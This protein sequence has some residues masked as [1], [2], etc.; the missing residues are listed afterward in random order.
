[1]K[2]PYKRELQKSHL[3]IHS[4]ITLKTSLIFTKTVL[5]NNTFLVDHTT[6]ASDNPLRFK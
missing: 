2:I 1:M 6:F 3:I 5:Q 4:I